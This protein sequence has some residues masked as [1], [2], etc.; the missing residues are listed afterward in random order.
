VQRKWAFEK[1][2]SIEAVVAQFL[3]E[4]LLMTF[5]SLFP[6]VCIAA[7]ML[8]FFNQLAGK[9]ISASS[10]STRSFWQPVAVGGVWVCCR[11]LSRILFIRI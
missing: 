1:Y 11:K 10:F 8:P 6:R 4:S 5:L 3:T 7:L 9:E 2:C